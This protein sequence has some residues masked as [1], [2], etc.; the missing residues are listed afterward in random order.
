MVGIS[1]SGKST[2]AKEMFDDFVSRGQRSIIV[3]RD[4]IREMIFGY[5][6]EGIQSYYERLDLKSCEHTVSKVQD[7]LIKQALKEGKIVIVDN[8]HLKLKYLKDLSKYGVPIDVEV[9]KTEYPVCVARDQKRRKQVGAEIIH[10]QYVQFNELLPFETSIIQP[11]VIEPIVQDESLPRAIVFDIDG[12][13]AHMKGRSPYDMSKVGEDELDLAVFG[14]LFNAYRVDYKIIVCTGRDGGP[15]GR[16]NT[17]KWLNNNFV[18]Y[19]EFHMRPEGS[20]EKD[21][22][23][24][25]RMWRDLVTRY[26]IVAMYDDRNQVVDHARKLGFKVFQV[27]EGDF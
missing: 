11:K 7:V 27:A 4:K 10:N 15:E 8:T 13:L 9:M 19:D 1:G 23:V 2:R 26:N 12:T 6:E 22:V 3:S 21:Y 20:H 16:Q 18:Y 5:N 25:E 14:V 17:I 24:K